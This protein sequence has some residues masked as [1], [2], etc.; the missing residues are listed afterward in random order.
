MELGWSKQIQAPIDDG[1]R[2]LSSGTCKC[3][4]PRGVRVWPATI[5]KFVLWGL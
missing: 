2:G 1:V 4:T 5:G 3:I